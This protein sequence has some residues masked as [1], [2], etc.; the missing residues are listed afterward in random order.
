MDCQAITPYGL[1]LVIL[2]KK[3][4][5]RLDGKAAS[6]GDNAQRVIVTL[7]RFQ[8]NRFGQDA[9]APVKLVVVAVCVYPD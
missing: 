6:L 3:L 9:V 8:D 5:L 1:G 2:S 7:Q 4:Q